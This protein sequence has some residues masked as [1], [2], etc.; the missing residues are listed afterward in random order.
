MGDLAA[1]VSDALRGD[2]T[3]LRGLVADARE[4]AEQRVLDGLGGRVE[5]QAAAPPLASARAR[6]IPEPG[7][8]TD[9]VIRL[10][11]GRQVRAM[12]SP[13]VARRRSSLRA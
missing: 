8:N 6:L 4:R 5:P 10:R 3:T 2:R 11:N 13:A 9:V 12:I 7:P 1:A